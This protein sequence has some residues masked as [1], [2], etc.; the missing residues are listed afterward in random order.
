MLLA[1]R[2]MRPQERWEAPF[3]AER[4][5][6]DAGLIMDD[7]S[8]LEIDDLEGS[9]PLEIGSQQDTEEFGP[10][11]AGSIEQDGEAHGL[12]KTVPASQMQVAYPTFSSFQGD[13]GSL[14]QPQSIT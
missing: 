7:P 1:V 8:F 14:M 6:G 2:G 9:L 3:T 10:S 11:P 13:K 12:Q 5:H 4:E